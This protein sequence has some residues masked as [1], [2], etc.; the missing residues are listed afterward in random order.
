MSKIRTFIRCALLIF[1]LWGLGGGCSPH[2]TITSMK[3]EYVSV[4][5][6]SRPNPKMTELIHQ[7]EK[8]LKVEM[9]PVIGYSAQYMEAEKPE[10]LLTNFT[11]DVM[12]QY[13]SDD[14]P[15]LSVDL[16]LMNV[17]GHRAP[18]RE[19]E[20]TVGNV[21]ETYS[22]DNQLVIARLKGE[23]LTRIFETCAEADK[24]SFS[25]NVKLIIKDNKLKKAEV[26]GLPVDP[27]KTYSIITL[28]YLT[29]GNDGMVA[30]KQAESVTLVGTLLRDYMMAYITEKNQKGE[31][32]SSRIDNR[33]I[34]E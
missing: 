16:A 18:V 7:Y 15:A 8:Q 30:L 20:I 26:N 23:Y 13:Q 2:Y 19:G 1:P 31:K 24:V 6:A 22:F 5:T 9:S 29:E 21:F 34:I 12:L 28:D 33:I 14:D 25:S 27:N 11:S 10:S 17:G 32:I 4:N 3:G